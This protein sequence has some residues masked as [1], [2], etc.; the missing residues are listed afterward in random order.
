MTEYKELPWDME[1]TIENMQ[2]MKEMFKQQ[3]HKIN[4]EGKGI[5]DGQELEFDFN[6]AIEALEKQVPKKTDDYTIMNDNRE[7]L[8]QRLCAICGYGLGEN[9][10]DYCPRCGQRIDWRD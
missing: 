9:V 3:L 1:T 6:R 7:I 8:Y 5:E 4:F 2:D 10:F